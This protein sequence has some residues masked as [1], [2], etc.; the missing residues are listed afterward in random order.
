MRSNAGMANRWGRPLALR[1][2]LRPQLELWLGLANLVIL[3]TY[4]PMK[5]EQCVPKR[6]HIKFRSRGITQKKANNIQN[7]AKV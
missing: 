6:R 7:T 4:P 2:S 3:H 1:A 5:I